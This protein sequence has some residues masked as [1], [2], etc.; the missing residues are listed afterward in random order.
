MTGTKARQFGS[1]AAAAA[2]SAAALPMAGAAQA[3]DM[4]LKAPVPVWVPQWTF[5]AEGGFLVSNF[6]RT[7]F[8]GRLEGAFD[9]KLGSHSLCSSVDCSTD[10]SGSLSPHRNIGWYGALS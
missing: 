5:G 4:P 9:D 7:A 10:R 2:A 8:P 1:L 3:A 6:S